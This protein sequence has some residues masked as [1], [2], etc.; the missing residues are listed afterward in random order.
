[1]KSNQ[2]NCQTSI[3]YKKKS[4]KYTWIQSCKTNQE[5]RFWCGTLEQQ[6]VDQLCNVLQKIVNSKVS[7][8][9]SWIKDYPEHK[10]SLKMN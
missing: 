6:F 4:M 8:T 10:N 1:M 3:E 2:E 9:K 7:R 5:S